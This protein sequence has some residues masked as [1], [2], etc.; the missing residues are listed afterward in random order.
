MPSSSTG[1]STTDAPD[2]S[3]I[4]RAQFATTEEG[5]DGVGMAGQIAKLIRVQVSRKSGEQRR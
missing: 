3:M 1:T 2:A 4:W 5:I